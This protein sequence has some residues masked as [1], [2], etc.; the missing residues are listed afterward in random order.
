MTIWLCSMLEIFDVSKGEEPREILRV[1]AHYSEELNWVWGG[2]PSFSYFYP[3]EL[4]LFLLGCL[5]LT[6]FFCL[7]AQPWEY[8][9]KCY[10]LYNE[11]WPTPP[12]IDGATINGLYFNNAYKFYLAAIPCGLLTLIVQ[13]Q[14]RTCSKTIYFPD[15]CRPFIQQ[16]HLFHDWL[17]VFLYSILFLTLVS[18]IMS[19]KTGWRHRSL[20]NG[21][22]VENI[23]TYFPALILVFISMPSLQLLYLIDGVRN[24][25][26]TIKAIGNQ[27]YWQYDYPDSP[28][29]NSY[30]KSG[31]Y[32]LLDRENRLHYPVDQTVQMLI[33]A[34]DVLHSWAIPIIGVKADAVPGRVNKLALIIQ[35]S[36]VF[37]G[38]CSEICGRNHRF[39][40][41]SLECFFNFAFIL[42]MNRYIVKII[43]FNLFVQLIFI[44]L[45]VALFTLMERKILGYQ[46]TRKGPNK[47]GPLGVFVPFADAL[48]LISKEISIPTQRN[49]FVFLFVPSLSLLVPMTLWRMY[50]SI[51]ECISFRFSSL[52]FLCVSALGVYAILGA[53]WRRNRKYTLMGAIRSV[54][55]SVSYE[56]SLSIVILHSIIFFNFTLHTPK[57]SPLS[58]FLFFPMIILFISSLAETNRSPFDFAE[59]ESELVSGFNTEYSSVPF[60]ILFL[61]EYLSILFMSALVRLVF[62]ATTVYD[63]LLIVVFWGVGF[64]WARGTLPRLRYDQL[65]MVAWK[66]MLPIVLCTIGLV[67]SI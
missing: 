41:I 13:N 22:M 26:L 37:F 32:R 55:Q 36:G 40:P 15:G 23:W 5:C 47:P 44:F 43:S 56:V 12:I 35:R 53:G 67:L 31:E 65:I 6:I 46:Q 54:A 62:N 21:H 64:I 11:A 16:V 3:R 30:L 18:I 60:V 29:F 17:V 63:G 28:T 48:K 33:T 7:L 10:R 9:R 42:K 51:F 66:R 49:K 57:A 25:T 45:A 8:Y 34:A 24:A 61:S 14:D 19:S 39:I 27:W 1:L 52:F 2:P 4:Q 58:T 38:Q 50:P 20:L 59:G